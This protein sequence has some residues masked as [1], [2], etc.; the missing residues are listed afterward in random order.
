MNARQAMKYWS[1]SAL[2]TSVIAKEIVE[3]YGGTIM[4]ETCLTAALQTVGLKAA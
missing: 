1:R 4:P 2:A 3:R